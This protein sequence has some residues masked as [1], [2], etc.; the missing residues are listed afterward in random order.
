MTIAEQGPDA[1]PG[2]A[3]GVPP[4]G[5]PPPEV[6][7]PPASPAGS[8]SGPSA[9]GAGPIARTRRRPARI[10]QPGIRNF[11]LSMFLTRL[12]GVTFLLF[13]TYNASGWS[14]WH[15][16]A[17]DFA[18]DW[19]VQLPIIALWVIFY[20]LLIRA[21]FRSLRPSGVALTIAF[22]GSIVWVLIDAG[23]VSL[24]DAGDLV[25]ISLYMTGGVLA[26]GVTWAGAWVTLTG[27]VVTDDLTASSGFL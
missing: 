22:I 9:S 1:A 2:S 4:S 26:V 23:I 8:G 13:S 14:L 24:E 10:K 12:F 3:G 21:T 25:V 18:S 16:V 19:M 6:S 27:Q 15:W 5:T 20:I 7:P 11:G 17:A